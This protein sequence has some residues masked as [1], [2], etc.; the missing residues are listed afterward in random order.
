MIK[1]ASEIRA[2]SDQ[3]INRKKSIESA[4][5]YQNNKI[6][7]AVKNGLTQC[8]FVVSP[9]IEKDVKNLYLLAGYTF[10][11]MPGTSINQ[12]TEIICW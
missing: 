3:D 2:L 10:E 7:W 9:P 5:E 1:S 6:D 8:T 4:V 12:N 11:P